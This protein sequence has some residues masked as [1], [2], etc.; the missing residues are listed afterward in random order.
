M[1]FYDINPKMFYKWVTRNGNVVAHEMT[2]WAGSE[3]N[4]CVLINK[5]V[6]WFIYKGKLISSKI[7][8]GVKG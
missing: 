1:K 5:I 7:Y 3:S 8:V 6:F 2:R 4:G